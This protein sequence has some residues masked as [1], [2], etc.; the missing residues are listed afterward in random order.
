M[1]IFGFMSALKAILWATFF[2]AGVLTIFAIITVEVIHPINLQIAATGYYDHIGCEHCPHAYESVFQSML[3][4]TQHIL[5]GDSWGTVNLPIIDKNP[6]A[7]IIL[8]GALV[9]INLGVLNLILAVIVD[10]AAEAR[11]RDAEFHLKEKALEAKRNDAK[12]RRLF[13]AMDEDKSGALSVDELLKGYDSHVEFRNAF[14]L[15][16]IAREDIETA[17]GVM[18]TDQSGQIDAEEFVDNIHKMKSQDTTMLLIFMR[19]H[20][21]EV[22]A[23]VSEQLRLMKGDILKA[24]KDLL[25][26]VEMSGSV[27]PS[28]LTSRQEWPAL[29]EFSPDQCRGQHVDGELV[30]M[31]E[32]L[33]R[34]AEEQKAALAQNSELLASLDSSLS[35][36]TGGAVRGNGK[37]F[38]TA[39]QQL[40]AKGPQGHSRRPTPGPGRKG[41]D[42]ASEVGHYCSQALRPPGELFGHGVVVGQSLQPPHTPPRPS[43][44]PPASARSSWNLSAWDTRT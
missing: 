3:T 30:A 38:G 21:N 31:L 12:L 27:L 26:R 24:S 37:P 34:T 5:A 18:D 32:Q 28:V 7:G 13:H 40:D 8:I 10:R 17:A 11:L 9:T 39:T 2:I 4:F 20:L 35:V 15:M 14:A 29:A 16:G 22:R 1:I 25:D 6:W 44:S 19:H 23:N 43:D 41:L 36:V 42:V 33:S